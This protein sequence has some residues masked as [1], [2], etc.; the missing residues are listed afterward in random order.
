MKISS[1]ESIN[2]FVMSW[3]TFSTW[4]CSS[5]YSN[6]W[7]DRLCD[8]TDTVPVRWHLVCQAILLWN[9]VVPEFCL[10]TWVQNFLLFKCHHFSPFQRDER[11]SLKRH[12]DT[13]CH[14]MIQAVQI[15][16]VL[17]VLNFN[18]LFHLNRKTQ[19]A[20]LNLFQSTKPLR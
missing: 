15:E 4:N 20:K 19:W 18:V 14:T 6:M 3:H 11:P 5:F 7:S 1:E 16:T 17:A 8:C 13:G 2:S 9:F 10:L 12:D